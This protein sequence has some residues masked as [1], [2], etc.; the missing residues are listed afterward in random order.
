MFLMP[1]IAYTSSKSNP[2][3]LQTI[4]PFSSWI[5]YGIHFLR[6]LKRHVDIQKKNLNSIGVHNGMGNYSQRVTILKE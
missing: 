1:K 3:L 5:D 6:N 4:A 2:A